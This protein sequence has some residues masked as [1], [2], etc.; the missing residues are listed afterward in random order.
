M[1]RPLRRVLRDIQETQA[2]GVQLQVARDIS[3]DEM[4]DSGRRQLLRELGEYELSIGTLAVVLQRPLTD[5]HG[6]DERIDIVKRAMQLAFQLKTTTV[7]FRI[8]AIPVD[9]AGIEY[10]TLQAVLNDLARHA[11]RVGA[12]PSITPSGDSFERTGELI[13][14]VTEGPIGVTL[15]PASLVPAG[16]SA[17][18][19][20]RDLVDHINNVLIRDAVRDIDGAIS[21]VP[22][23]RGEVDWDGLLSLVREAEFA[24]WL[25]VVRT[26][27]DDKPGDATRAVSFVRRVLSE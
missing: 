25:T 17:A 18:D 8:G 23:S 12:I 6:L 4:G 16:L 19:G 22:V 21:E 7:T 1:G 10:E 2:T 11:N 14:G 15:D 27:G 20:F 9:A 5:L 24:G 26:Q 13:A 3:F